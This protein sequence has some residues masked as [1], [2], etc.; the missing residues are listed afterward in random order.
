MN[1][2]SR[3]CGRIA[4]ARA[5]NIAIIAMILVTATGLGIET[6]EALGA[7]FGAAIL[8]AYEIA[9]AALV[10]E[11]ASARD[12]LERIETMVANLKR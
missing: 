3:L 8:I 2:L 5:F 9:L 1:P 12:A 10:V 11:A 4:D 6:S 7:R